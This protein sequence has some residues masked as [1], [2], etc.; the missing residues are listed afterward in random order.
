MDKD[1]LKKFADTFGTVTT[2]MVSGCMVR[3]SVSPLDQL[4]CCD[5]MQHSDVTLALTSKK[6]DDTLSSLVD[7]RFASKTLQFS[8][9]I[10]G[11][12]HISFSDAF[13]EVRS[14]ESQ[15]DN[16][17]S[18]LHHDVFTKTSNPSSDGSSSSE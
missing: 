6:L 16:L 14:L 5:G 2:S 18:N 11:N 13:N 10:V 3:V 1:I 9:D 12:R 17:I 15:C 8:D 4:S 7:A